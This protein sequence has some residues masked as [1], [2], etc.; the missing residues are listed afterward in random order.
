[1]LDENPE[2]LCIAAQDAG[3]AEVEVFIN[4]LMS[5]FRAREDDIAMI[6]VR[7]TS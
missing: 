2:K 1:M 4:H 3:S 5:I 6:A 7:R